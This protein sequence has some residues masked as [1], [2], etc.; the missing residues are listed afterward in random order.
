MK[1]LFGIIAVAAIVAAAGWNFSQNNDKGDFAS[2]TLANIESIAA[3][4]ASSISSENRGYCVKEYQGTRD[5]CAND[6]PYGAP[7]CNGTIN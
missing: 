6:G 7:R 2:L 3:C 1:K 5:V 4:E